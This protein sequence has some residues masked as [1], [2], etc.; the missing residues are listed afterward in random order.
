MNP[1]GVT[2]AVA[3][4]RENQHRGI[5]LDELANLDACRIWG[6]KRKR[7]VENAWRL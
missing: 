1:C 5:L 4:G 7:V 6:G 2:T 3:M